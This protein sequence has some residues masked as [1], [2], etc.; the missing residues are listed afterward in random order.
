ML[1]ILLSTIKLAAVC[2]RQD[3]SERRTITPRAAHGV[4]VYG[5]YLEPEPLRPL[6][7][8]ALLVLGRLLLRAHPSP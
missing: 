5:D 7:Q 8:L 6:P 1:P 4:S 2:G 3:R